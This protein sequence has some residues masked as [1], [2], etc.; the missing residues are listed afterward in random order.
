MAATHQTDTEQRVVH[1]PFHKSQAG[2]LTATMPD[3][4]HPH[5]I[6]PRGYYMVFIVN[7]DGVPS[8]ARFVF[9]H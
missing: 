6:A 4:L 3:G 1:L 8:E 7:T 5:G 9:L 2:V